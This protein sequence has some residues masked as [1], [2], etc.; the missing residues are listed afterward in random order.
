MLGIGFGEFIL[1]FVVLLIVVGPDK[2]PTLMKTVGRTV[3]GLRNASRDIRSAVGID[4]LM[5]DDYLYSPPARRAPPA[6][7]LPAG[8]DDLDDTE[9]DGDGSHADTDGEQ[10]PKPTDDDVA[11]IAAEP[12]A[13]GGAD[14]MSSGP[15]ES[16]L[17]G[18]PP[19]GPSELAAPPLPLTPPPVQASKPPG[20]PAVASV[21]P[22]AAGPGPRQG[23]GPQ[24]SSPPPPLPVTAPRRSM[25]PP[26]PSSAGP[27]TASDDD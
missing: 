26:L 10:V 24:A 7:T 8:V 1:I 14:A 27:N 6:Q 19:P 13:P 16:Y 17:G 3:R 11:Q 22:P 20:P 25:P 23:S 12:P 9:S 21:P 2:L 18:F 15:G 5:R 4:E